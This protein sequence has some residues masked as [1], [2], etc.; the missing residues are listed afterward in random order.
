MVPLTILDRQ[1]SVPNL[2]SAHRRHPCLCIDHLHAPFEHSG[3]IR[4]EP[5]G[6]WHPMP[7]GG[8]PS[9]AI[10]SGSKTWG[11]GIHWIGIHGVF[12][13]FSC[14]GFT[15]LILCLYRRCHSLKFPDFDGRW[16]EYLCGRQ[17]FKYQR[18]S[19]AFPCLPDL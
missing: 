10:P 5:G 9:Y 15:Y 11:H 18:K 7:Q 12:Q 14:V 6:T 2:A 8:H 19:V 3:F 17:S 16:E 1:Q 13:G 4:L